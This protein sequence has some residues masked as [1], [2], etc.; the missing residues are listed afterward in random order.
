VS[1]TNTA[2]EPF[3]NFRELQSGDHFG[4][5][6]ILYDCP[7]TATVVAKGY[8]TFARLSIEN[9]RKLITEIPTF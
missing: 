7:R 2:R 5:I 4:E 8:C 9:Y 6:G 3:D 1:I